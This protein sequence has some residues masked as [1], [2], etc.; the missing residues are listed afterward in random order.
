M[1]SETF[2]LIGIGGI[3]MSA[4]A[5]ILL[6]QG[7]RVQGS[8]VS[9]S[10]LTDELAKEGAK[11][12]IGHR[13][14]GL[15]GTKVVYTSA[16]NEKNVEFAFAKNEGFSLLHRSDLLDFLMRKK[17]PLLVTG[18]HGKTTTTSLLASS[19]LEAGV[20]P[21]FVVGGIVQSL[22][23]NGR[24]GKGNY[25]VAE[26]D[27]SD[28][29]FLKTAAFGAIVT[30]CDNDHLDYWKTD[31]RQNDAFKT[32]FSAVQEKKH[33]F[34]CKDDLRLSSLCPK[35]F[36]YGFS[37]DAD[38]HVNH[39]SQDENG[40]G[41]DLSFQNKIYP[42]IKVPLFGR[43]NA[44][45]CAAVFGLCLTLGVGE[46]TLRSSFKKFQGVKRRLE[47]KGEKNGVVCYD[48]YG[49]HPTEVKA[50]LKAFKERM[51]GKRVVVL[52][53]PHRYTRTKELWEDFVKSFDDADILFLTDIY[54]ASEA[55]LKGITGEALADD[56]RKHMHGKVIF[57][58][59]SQLENDVAKILCPGDALLTLGAG[60]VT[61]A[62]EKILQKYAKGN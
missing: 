1:E 31:E 18:T 2:H 43:H 40:I 15:E 34:W 62:G 58:P 33:L 56:T 37:K 7:Y 16:V 3:G 24:D 50:T 45:N 14:E 35:G 59:R 27:E 30:N 46:E 5:R 22:Q 44:L 38:L 17:K 32:F 4:L 49:H 51:K 25:F 57:S 29:S 12:I 8:D 28:G 52:F 13:A 19:L 10:P 20:D 36:S 9:Q 42:S 48:D 60:D 21:S 11:I 55:P 41:F 61:Y 47:W 54:A 26:A 23:T 53:Q 6:K 39:F